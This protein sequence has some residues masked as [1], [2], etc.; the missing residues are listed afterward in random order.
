MDIARKAY[1]KL[2]AWKRKERGKSAL[3]IEGARR[4]GK[5]YLAEKFAK[6]EYKSALI[7]DFAKA[8]QEIHDLFASESDDFD[9][10]FQALSLFYKV[11]LYP[12]ESCIVFD[13]VQLCPKARQ[14]IKYLVADG[15]YDYLETGSLIT[16]RKNV[17]NIL[18]PSE[19]ERL[20][21][22]PL[23]FEEFLQ[24]FGDCETY[25]ILQEFYT[26]KK[27]LGEVLYQTIMKSFRKYLL[28][29]GMPQVVNDFSENYNFESA[30]ALKRRILQ[31]Y[32]DDV[33]KFAQGY[34]SQVFSLFDRIPG[35]LSQKKV[36]NFFI[37]K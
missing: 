28:I 8:P 1:H 24:A 37:Y 16:L 25:P 35:Q 19:E 30:D 33:V 36:Y 31:L 34:E 32:H 9:T 4:V 26:K 20:K 27:P 15:R 5:T 11:R 17:E 10:L 14:L 3:L 23:D 29:G 18:I 22:Y 7:I 12:R 13:E 21:L 2:L 6:T